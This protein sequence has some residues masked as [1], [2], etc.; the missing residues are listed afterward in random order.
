MLRLYAPEAPY[1]E[2]QL[3]DIFQFFLVQIVQNLKQPSGK[4]AKNP[5][6]ANNA[7]VQRITDVPYY[8]E[9]YYLLESLAT[10]KSVCLV[11][12]LPES[13]GMIL[14]FFEGFF[15]IVR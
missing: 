10:I 7:S 12:D 13:D 8:N 15:S 1:T 6:G 14:E 9:Y 2:N 3:K 4:N 11:T 5:G